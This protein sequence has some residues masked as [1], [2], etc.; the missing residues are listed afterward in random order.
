[1]LNAFDWIRLCENGAELIATLDAIKSTPQI[2]P[3][4]IRMGPPVRCI[5]G[6]C[7]RCWIFPRLPESSFCETCQAIVAESRNLGSVSR[8]CL[9]IWGAVNVLPDLDLNEN[10]SRSVFMPDDTHFL[11][12][13]N[14]RDVAG[15]LK[16][17]VMDQDTGLKGLLTIFPTTGKRPTFTMGDILCRAIYHDSRF[18]M[19][20]LRIRYFAR[21][22]Q[23]KAPHLREK[24]GLLIFDV[25]EFMLLLEMAAMFKSRL[26][27]HDRDAIR[28][29][30]DIQNPQEQAFQWG[31]LMGRLDIEARDMLTHW[32]LR[33]WSPNRIN[34]LCELADHAA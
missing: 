5:D 21:P 33:E 28:Q 4:A 20:R 6:P 1:M 15:W 18:P 16:Q 29:I 11:V 14:G 27:F 19:D 24:Q 13:V 3:D 10:K 32:E 17:V 9:L 22:G 8:K 23:V 26:G 7:E 31:R 34:L 25:L 2:F 30:A 12:V